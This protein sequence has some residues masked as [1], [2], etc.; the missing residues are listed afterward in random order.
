MPD[1]LPL[2][3]FLAEKTCLNSGEAGVRAS[4][5]DGGAVSVQEA[6]QFSS[7]VS[8]SIIH[9]RVSIDRHEAVR[10]LAVGELVASHQIRGGL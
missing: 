2:P 8:S 9:E 3:S 4:S 1:Y 6:G 5:L 10:T 7:S